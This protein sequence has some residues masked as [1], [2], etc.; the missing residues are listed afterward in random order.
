MTKEELKF[1]LKTGETLSV[2][3]KEAKQNLPENL[4]ETICAFLNTEGGRI[5]LGVCD[6][7]TIS[8]VD[9]ESISKLKRDIAN[10]SNNPQ[11]LDPV[12]MLTAREIEYKNKT[13]LL[14]DVPV[15]S[16]VHKCNG[17]VYAR[18]EDGDYKIT[19]L[20]AIAGLVNRKQSY[21]TEQRVYPYITL[22]DLNPNLI[23]RAKRLIQGNSPG[24][25]WV[26]LPTDELLRR[27][28]FYRKA[29]D[30]KEGYTLAAI[31][32]FGKDET[33]SSV[34]PAYKFDALLRKHNID[35]YDD[36]LIVRT[37][38]LDAYD[39]LMGF[40]AKH[41]NDPFYLEGDLR[42]SLRDKIFRELVA[43]IIAHREYLDGRP[44]TIII[45]KDKV[46]F[47]NP[48]IP[49]G[50]GIIDPKHFTPFSKN[51]TICKLMLQTGRIEE[52][53]S[54]IRNVGKYL[55]LYSKQGKFEFIEDDMFVTNVYV[56]EPTLQATQK[57]SQKTAQKIIELIKD[58]PQ[59]T[60]KEMAKLIGITEDGIKYHLINLRKHSKIQR[61]GYDK[62]G[63]W[64]ILKQNNLQAVPK[65][66]KTNSLIDHPK[67]TQ[68][69]TRK[70]TQK[71]SQK[72][73][74]KIIKLITGNPNITRKEL[75]AKI[76][77]TED[78]IKY[79]LSI[80]QKNKIIK[81]IGADKGGYWKVIKPNNQD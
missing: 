23:T 12:F 55:P 13:I 15:S 28:G 71:S 30:G 68:K 46:V 19:R 8:G 51:P 63:Y 33:I 2:E 43:N 16:L 72:T 31:L 81:R 64:E 7:G 45:Y 1:I 37:N 52:V 18:N 54:G 80:M 62:G 75:A 36:R 20:E 35:R 26:E 47:S 79:H 59:I 58:N 61:I 32:F 49:H 56:G 78:G 9:P 74:Q 60:R 76:G 5:L 34:A 22:D 40:I 77:L 21:F 27:A 41:L 25:P 39:L 4:F 10:L 48:N 44:A 38:L 11:K 70:T 6:D 42:I 66:N 14:I 3:F 53:G 57:S 73:T 65:L 29:S 69:T 17:I 24:H 67:T 50:R